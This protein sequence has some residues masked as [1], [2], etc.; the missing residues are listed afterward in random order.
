MAEEKEGGVAE[1]RP[2][3]ILTPPSRYIFGL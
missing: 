2:R 1:R 3:S